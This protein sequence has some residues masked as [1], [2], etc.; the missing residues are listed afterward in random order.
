VNGLKLGLLL[1]GLLVAITVADWQELEWI[2]YSGLALLGIAWVWSRASLIGIGIERTLDADRVFAGGEVHERFRLFNRSHLPKTWISVHDRSTLPGHATSRVASVRRRSETVWTA[3]TRADLRGR[4]RLGPVEL[5]SGDPFGLFTQRKQLDLYH[6]LLV[7]PRLVPLPESERFGGE[8]SGATRIAPGRSS[9]SPVIR[10]LR[11]YVVGDPWNQIAWRPSARH[12][13]LLV[14]ELEPDPVAD[15]WILLDLV[16]RD[17]RHRRA[18]EHA[19]SLAASFAIERLDAARDVGLLV[20]RRI[21]AVVD[22][23]AG[24]RQRLR[25]LEALAVVQPYGEADPVTLISRY[26]TRFSRST[27]VV[28]ISTGSGHGLVAPLRH[29]RQRGVPL[30]A[31]ATGVRDAAN[32]GWMEVQSLGVEVIRYSIGGDRLGGFADRRSRAAST[33]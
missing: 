12:G 25:I 29:L 3:T 22:A 28:V 5:H 7:Y 21:P 19:V 32:D 18:T 15:E 14:K 4:Y 16:P 24:D 13:S 2:V 8:L 1:L 23:D 26:A 20:N 31:I 6:E 33:P 9:G 11:Q 30:L 17:G 10:S 27:N